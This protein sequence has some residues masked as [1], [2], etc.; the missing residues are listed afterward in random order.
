[1]SKV[2]LIIPCYN[3]EKNIKPL[4]E[5]VK[6][7][8]KK[9]DLEF[10]VVINGSKDKTEKEINIYKKKIKYI[11][12]VKVKKNIGFGHG[13]KKGLKKSTSDIVCYAHGDLQIKL[14]NVL[15]A[16]NIY[17]SQKNKN[18]F[19][20]G[21]RVNR[22]FFDNFFTYSMSFFNS[23]IFRKSLID[24]HAQPNLFRKAMINN[25]DYLPNNMIL[26]LYILL[27]AKIKKYEV[28]RFKVKFLNRKYGSGSNDSLS[29]KIKYSL[30]SIL[31][32][33]RIFLNGN[34]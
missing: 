8:Q 16:Y 20:K 15:T 28:L 11:K 25:I 9:I 31:S 5:Q 21:F 4:F 18:I 3:E 22:S 2:S 14:I 34:F 12:I 6:N 33:L 13:V 27:A 24:I 23:L 10:I 26:D 29:K 1:M 32:S 7:L 19:V 17:K 30:L